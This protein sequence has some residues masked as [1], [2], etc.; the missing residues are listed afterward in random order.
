MINFL[1]KFFSSSQESHVTSFNEQQE[2]N[3]EV[4][5]IN[6]G[7]NYVELD[8]I[9]GSVGKYYDFDSR[10]RPK[11]QISGKRFTEIK[12][13][14]RHGTPLPPV[15]LYQIRRDFYVLDGN[16]RVAA[17]KELG[18]SKIRASIIEL[19]S[20]SNTME[21]LLY[22]ERQDF[23]RKT[24]LEET[25]HLTEVG[26]YNYLERQIEKHKNHLTNISGQES[27]FAKAAKD[28]F[29]TI[30]IPLTTIIKNGSLIKHF[31]SRTIADLYTY[32]AH[33][34]W[35]RNTNRRYGIGID[36]LIPRTMEDF[37]TAMLEKNTP[38]YPEMKRTITAFILINS[39]A[40]SEA[41]IIE[42]L[43]AIDEIKE[44]H[45]VHGAIDILVKVIL[46]RDFL[47]SDAETIAEFMD[48]HVRKISGV[49][50]TQT[51]IP[52]ISRVKE[53]MFGG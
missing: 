20:D 12:K 4:R 38:D 35:E 44:I 21:N 17:A 37:R 34:H 25:I 2:A 29:N 45:G 52:G 23:F 49:K 47:A 28:W 27:D 18:Q 10:F 26:K 33:H 19:C 48:E 6:H 13:A 43:F 51:L 16:H 40:S 15:Q 30:Y 36:R 5:F 31:P 42:R 22:M 1:K 39:T 11:K 46:K 8:R 24:G 32:I 53:D 41:K 7:E 3:E 50:G 14:I 9:I